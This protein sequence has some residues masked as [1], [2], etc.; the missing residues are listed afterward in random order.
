M[1]SPALRV[2]PD[3]EA[4]RGCVMPSLCGGGSTPL[5]AALGLA[6][7]SAIATSSTHRMLVEHASQL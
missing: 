5:G 7:F 6:I 2:L 1:A 4:T 3:G